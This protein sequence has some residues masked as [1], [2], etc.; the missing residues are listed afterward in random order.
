MEYILDIDSTQRDPVTFP[1]PNDYTVSLNTPLYNVTHMSIIAGRIPNTQLLIN[2]GNKQFQIKDD[3]NT[4]KTIILSEGTYTNGTAL[5]TGLQT[6]LSAQ[7]CVDSVVFSSTT[8][9]L[10]FSNASA[11]NTFSFNLYGGS[12]GYVDTSPVGTPYNIMGFNGSN[13][14]STGSRPVR[15]QHSRLNHHR[16]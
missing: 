3:T 8:R 11:A 12:N 2:E 5:A 1:S 9:S 6:D 14:S 13:V 15:Y 16:G 10:T 4:P 7:C